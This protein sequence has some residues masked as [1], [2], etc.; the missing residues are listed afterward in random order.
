[1]SATPAAIPR[2]SAAF[3]L[4][5]AL[6]MLG[7]NFVWISY[8]NVLLPTLVERTTMEYRGLI[9]GLIGFFGTLLGVLVSLLSGIASDRS[10][11]P[12]GRRT[13][14]LLIG[15]VATLPFI[16]LA[17]LF[18]QPSLAVVVVSFL[19]MECFTNVGNGAWWP[20]I[21]DVVPEHQR[22]LSSGIAGLYALIGAAMGV[23]LVSLLNQHGR[24]DAALW[25][26]AITLAVSGIVSALVVRGWDTPAVAERPLDRTSLWTLFREMF[27]VHRLV[28]VFF[29]V[30]ASAFLAN[31]AL[32]SLQFFARYFFQT[33]F[34]S[35][36]PDYA[37]RLMGGISLA[38]TAAAAVG[39]GLLSD[40]IGRRRLILASM[41][42][43]GA[44]TLVMPFVSSFT[45][46]LVL[47]ALRSLA[48]GPIV[49]VIPALAAD[50][51][52]RDEAGKYMAY[53]NLSTGL[54]TAVAS[55]GF[56][57]VL[58]RIDRSG[59]MTLFVVSAALFVA[60]GVLFLV[61]VP[62]RQLHSSPEPGPTG[63]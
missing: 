37:F 24:T 18:R 43:S 23:G 20:L 56:G 28:V 34:P 61:K 9:T 62:E 57:L 25:V 60:G 63:C 16:A 42:A 49:G 58:T 55:L 35:V 59:F 44:L 3:L 31:M 45:V 40:R 50:L 51:A 46:F 6:L 54:A 2:R 48:T 21:V 7:A 4:G 14:S 27:R 52:P 38:C 29:W 32:N 33:F 39:A 22:G 53:I 13:P 26:L 10:A 30:V 41:F 12:W 8:N 15:T 19:G 47:A 5:M 1:M 11:S 17:A 36:G